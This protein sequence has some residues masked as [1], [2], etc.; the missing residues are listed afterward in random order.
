MTLSLDEHVAALRD[1]GD[2]SADGSST[3]LRVRRSLE[4]GDGVR[5]K[6]SWGAAGGVLLVAS[7]SWGFATGHLAPRPAI[8][9]PPAALIEPEREPEP[10][11]ARI[12]IAAPIVVP[13]AAP[14]PKL[15]VVA[16]PS[17]PPSRLYAKAHEL[18][19]HDADYAAALAAFDDYLAREPDGQFVSEARYNRGLCLVR[20]GRLADAKVALQPFAEGSVL[21]GYRQQEAAMLIEKID[22]R[23]NKAP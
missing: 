8:V 2:E 21:S 1:L 15:A 18:Y 9:R 10:E 4:R 5:R 6:V 14:A 22:R 3:R 11:P 13:V 20:L 16:A 7:V 19:F 23:L 12:V 17:P